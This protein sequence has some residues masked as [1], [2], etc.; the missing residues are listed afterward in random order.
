LFKWVVSWTYV[1]FSPYTL[2]HTSFTTMRLRCVPDLVSLNIWNY[3]LVSGL[4][5]DRYWEVLRV[6]RNW[7]PNSDIWLM[8]R[9]ILPGQ[10]YCSWNSWLCGSFS[11]ADNV[12]LNAGGS[13]FMIHS[14]SF[15]GLSISSTV[16]LSLAILHRDETVWFLRSGF[17]LHTLRL[18][19]PRI[20]SPPR[21]RREHWVSKSDTEVRELTAFILRHSPHPSLI[22]LCRLFPRSLWLPVRSWISLSQVKPEEFSCPSVPLFLHLSLEVT[23]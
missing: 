9:S 19:C 1:R 16:H 15:F 7:K 12:S 21:L 8:T 3:S 6:R 18:S 22:S 23:E 17:L 11:T 5:S 20:Q 14:I 10:I 13:V 2:F 4:W